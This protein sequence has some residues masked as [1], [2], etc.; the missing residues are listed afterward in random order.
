MGDEIFGSSRAALEEAFFARE[1]ERLRQQLRDLDDTK[2]KDRLCGKL[3]KTGKL[4]RT[5]H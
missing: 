5:S 4:R 3:P 2:R 1:N